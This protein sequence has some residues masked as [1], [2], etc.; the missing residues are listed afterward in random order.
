MWKLEER[1]SKSYSVYKTVQNLG[2]I[3]CSK[4]G[5]VARKSGEKNVVTNFLSF[6]FCLYWLNDLFSSITCQWLK[7]RWLFSFVNVRNI[8]RTKIALKEWKQTVKFLMVGLKFSQDSEHCCMTL[9]HLFPS[10]VWDVKPLTGT[11][12]WIQLSQCITGAIFRVVAMQGNI[13]YLRRRRR[14]KILEGGRA[15]LEEPRNHC[16]K[17]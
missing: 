3:S 11:A 17:Y 14:Q 2:L 7:L 15:G 9:H 1:G 4:C 12:Y 6:C 16:W 5:E 10:H 8:W 13:L